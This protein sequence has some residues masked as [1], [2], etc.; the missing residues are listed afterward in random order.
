MVSPK[1]DLLRIWVSH[2]SFG[3][4][5]GGCFGKIY[6]LRNASDTHLCTTL[7]HNSPHDELWLVRVC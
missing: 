7:C 2:G 5:G 6:Y 4:G 3:G 1:D